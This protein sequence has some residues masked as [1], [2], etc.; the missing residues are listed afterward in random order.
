MIFFDFCRFAVD[1]NEHCLIVAHNSIVINLNINDSF[2]SSKNIS[3]STS[4]AT[5]M[6]DSRR[7]LYEKKLYFL[8]DSFDIDQQDPPFLSYNI[9][10]KTITRSDRVIQ[11]PICYR[12]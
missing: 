12:S 8:S 2:I 4:A 1:A 3:T 9:S 10:T 7:W 6:K 11:P 5:V